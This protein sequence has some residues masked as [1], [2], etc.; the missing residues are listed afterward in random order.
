MALLGWILHAKYGVK[1]GPHKIAWTGTSLGCFPIK[2]A[3]CKVNKSSWDPTEETWKLHWKVEGSKG[4]RFFFGWF[5]NK[6]YLLK[7][8][9]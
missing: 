7:Q 5:S 9:G 4:F 8:K 6:G 1:K 3:Y 2:S